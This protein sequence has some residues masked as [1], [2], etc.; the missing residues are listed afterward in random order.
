MILV[1]ILRVIGWV[2]ATLPEVVVRALCRLLG[3]LIFFAP[4]RRRTVLLSNLHHAFPDKP[5]GWHP[6]IGRES[7]RRMVE[8]GLFVLASP[9]FSEERWR[10]LIT[11]SAASANTLEEF[12]NAGG[13]GILL[14]FHLTLIETMVF[15]PL[16]LDGKYT[17]GAIYRPFDN[18]SLDRWILKTRERFGGRLL[19][20]KKGFGEAQRLV[21]EGGWTGVLFDQNAGDKG[22]L[23]YSFGRVASATELPSI[24]C[25]KFKA[26]AAMAFTERTAFWRGEVKFEVL[27]FPKTPEGLTLVNNKW[28]EN[29]LS[30]SDDHCADWLWMHKRWKT[31]DNP[32]KRLRLEQKKSLLEQSREYYGLEE[33][34]R[35]TR[36]WIRMPNWL[37]DVVM[38]LPLLRAIHAGRPDAE[39][40][41]LARKTYCQFLEELPFVNKVIALPE[42]AQCCNWSYFQ[43]FR[44]LR[45][46]YPD[47][48]LL[49]TNSFRGDL[50]A[51]LTGC[52]QRF[53]MLRPGKRRP[54]LTHCWRLPQDLNENKVHQIRVWEQYLNHFGL[55]ESLG[56]EPI[57]GGRNSPQP[58]AM[59]IG[60][61][62]GTENQPSKRWPVAHWR[63]LIEQLFSYKN[64]LKIVLFGTENDQTITKVVAKGL[65]KESV[66]DLAG[67]TDLEGF[68]DQLR[69][70]RLLIGNDTGGAH[71]ANAL[72]VPVVVVYGPT[73]PLRT[74]PVFEAPVV[75]LQPPGC[76]PEGGETIDGVPVETV[77]GA[78]LKL[79]KNA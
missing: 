75:I 23:I 14:G 1:T 62:C 22:T 21:R 67:K 31:Q 45:H 25:R 66:E 10:A 34:P 77:A 56:L 5:V 68:L 19:S 59:T 69:N 41:V 49:F 17:M 9:F 61:I 65:P 55:Q 2:L 36:F 27:K 74:G 48:F 15:T 79:L 29:Y 54:L 39:I 64:N 6:V 43:F 28:L 16:L 73:N 47:T 37:G 42:K 35:R 30:S 57:F 71:L 63:G 18:K 4:T 60:L 12:E 78:A 8:S 33:H 76:P 38:A 26:P 72:G 3:D 52:P 50:E 24:L 20:R 13:G 44:N 7:C 11:L 40:T 53:G 46:Q 70:C 51:R 32:G 58:D